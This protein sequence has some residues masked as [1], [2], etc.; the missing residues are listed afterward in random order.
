MLLDGGF[1]EKNE[2]EGL[3]KLVGQQSITEE[4]DCEYLTNG[5][6]M[7]LDSTG[8]VVPVLP[9]QGK[10]RRRCMS[11]AGEVKYSAE[12]LTGD[13]ASFPSSMLCVSWPDGHP[14]ARVM[15]CVLK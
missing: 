11:L 6:S 13:E 8:S 12:M 10:W 15:S 5:L 9:K 3:P 14:V 4:R 1:P 7:R 2:V